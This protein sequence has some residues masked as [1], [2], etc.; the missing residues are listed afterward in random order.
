MFTLL[1]FIILELLVFYS[2]LLYFH[3][4]KDQQKQKKKQ[5]NNIRLYLRG[6]PYPGAKEVEILLD[7]PQATVF[8]YVQA[9]V[10]HG[11]TGTNRSERLRRVWEP[12]YT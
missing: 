2:H 1:N 6:A 4:D 3:L 7:N 8:S 10:L 9:L 5:E 12:T 11:M